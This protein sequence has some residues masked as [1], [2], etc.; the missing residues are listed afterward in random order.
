MHIFL[1]SCKCKEILRV[2]S[3]ALS[4]LLMPLKPHLQVHKV[5]EKVIQLCCGFLKMDKEF[6]AGTILSKVRLLFSQRNRRC[7]HR[8]S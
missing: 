4:L 3:A 8:P 5:I 1:S 2:N 6:Q 7:L